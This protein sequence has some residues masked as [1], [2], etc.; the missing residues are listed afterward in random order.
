MDDKNLLNAVETL[1]AIRDLYAKVRQLAHATLAI[2]D[3]Q[4]G[5]FDPYLQEAERLRRWVEIATRDV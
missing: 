1:N 3:S 2:Y 4:R 5:E